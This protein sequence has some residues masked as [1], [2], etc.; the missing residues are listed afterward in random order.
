MHVGGGLAARVRLRGQRPAGQPVR[1]RARQPGGASGVVGD[2]QR[3]SGRGPAGQRA[4]QHDGGAGVQRRPRLVH[5]EQGQLGG[6]SGLVG[7]GAGQRRGQP[8]LLQVAGGQRGQRAGA[9]AGEVEVVEHGGGR[10]QVGRARAVHGA[11][12]AQ[13]GQ[14]RHPGRRRR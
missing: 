8:G 5:H 10:G 6:S 3:A 13:V 7:P 9:V 1:Q 12:V 4:F 14:D 2:Q 11:V